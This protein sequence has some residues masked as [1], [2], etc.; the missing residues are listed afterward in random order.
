MLETLRLLITAQN[1][2]SSLKTSTYDKSNF[3]ICREVQNEPKNW[4]I[5]G[6]DLEVFF[7]A[8]GQF[9]DAFLDVSLIALDQSNLDIVIY[10]N[11]TNAI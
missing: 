4:M 10:I 8:F 11:V 3:R 1:S 6:N 7:D 9:L 5:K 2:S